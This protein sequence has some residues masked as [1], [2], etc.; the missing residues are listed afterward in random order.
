MSEYVHIGNWSGSDVLTGIQVI[1]T[2]DPFFQAHH[3]NQTEVLSEDGSWT[4]VH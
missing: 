4:K 2:I 3:N 1:F